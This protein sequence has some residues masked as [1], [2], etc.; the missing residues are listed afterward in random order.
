[1]IEFLF[2]NLEFDQEVASE[3]SQ[4][5]YDNEGDYESAVALANGAS[6]LFTIHLHQDIRDHT[7]LH[8]HGGS[9]LGSSITHLHD[10]SLA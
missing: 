2:G 5:G 6:N 9:S 1:M 4:Y 3:D 7:N 10:L 8:H